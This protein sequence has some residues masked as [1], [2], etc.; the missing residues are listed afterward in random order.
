MRHAVRVVIVCRYPGFKVYEYDRSPA[1]NSY[2]HVSLS[3]L[4]QLIVIFV[5]GATGCTVD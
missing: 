2:E 5:A 4:G 3:V 1:I